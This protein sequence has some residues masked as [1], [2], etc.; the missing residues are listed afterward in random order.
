[1]DAMEKGGTVETGESWDYIIV[2][3]GSAGCVLADR[4]TEDG[5]TRVLLLEAGGRDWHPFIHI[6]AGFYK[7][8]SDARFNW[9]FSSEPEEATA[10]RRIAI[11]R[12]RVLGGSSSINGSL[13]VRGQPLDYDT[14]AQMGNRGWTYEEVLPA[15]RRMETF[16]GAGEGVG[17]GGDAVRG[18]EGPLHVRETITRHPLTD[19]FIEAAGEAGYPRNADY[20]S[21]T[22]DG[23]GYYQL[24]QK[25]RRRSSAATAYLRSAMKRDN[26]SVRTHAAAERI[27]VEDG[28]AVGVVYRRGGMRRFVRASREV[29][30]SAGAVKTPQLLELSGVGNPD[31][32]KAAG[33]PVL[34]ALPGVGENY[35]DHYGTRQ[36]WRI[37]NAVTLNEMARGWRFLYELARYAG[38]GTGMLTYGAGL[39]FGFIR[40]REGLSTPDIQY[41]LAHASYADASTRELHRH[42]GMTLAT[43]QM[44]PESRGSIHVAS[45]DPAIAP[46]IR[47][48]F[49]A[50]SEDRRVLVEGIKIARAIV[51]RP[52]L[53]AYR[54]EEIAPGPDV[55]TDDEI[56]AFARENGQT[57][58]HMVGT[59]KMGSDPLAV[60]D[61]RLRVHGIPGLRIVDAS[62]MPT[63]VSGNTNAAT[64]MIAERASDMIREDGKTG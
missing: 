34:R 59:A 54:G 43:Y 46:L 14:W 28:R 24:T 53:D 1:M 56:L 12:G 37:R 7:L 58:Y 62:V 63:L 18:R 25:G 48:N 39:V 27:V 38:S 64:L 5:H 44:R 21:G 13:F 33:I 45:A 2:G 20:N 3:A 10:N 17:T 26:L 35:R 9:R 61:E 22:Q 60:V 36:S 8:L 6:P 57:L 52:A 31:I 51:A 55:A 40:S 49:L 16:A 47:P 15:F 32:L 29:I 19:A 11:P 4:L 30:L 50:E 41:H 42:S 23:F